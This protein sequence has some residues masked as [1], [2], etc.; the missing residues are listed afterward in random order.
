MLMDG[1]HIVEADFWGWRRVGMLENDVCQRRDRGSSPWQREK[2][3]VVKNVGQTTSLCTARG[4]SG[5]EV[6][7]PD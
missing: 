5:F 2:R 6:L 3:S 7:P 4:S 1:K